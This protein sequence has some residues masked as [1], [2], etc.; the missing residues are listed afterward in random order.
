M[1]GSPRWKVYTEDGEY[2]ASCKFVEDAAAIV[3]MRG[4]GTTIRDGH[5]RIVWTDGAQRLG[6]ANRLLRD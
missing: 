5:R 3:A 2:V 6:H 1:S 4:D